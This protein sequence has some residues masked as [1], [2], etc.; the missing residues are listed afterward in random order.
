MRKKPKRFD[1]G[2]KWV[3]YDP[4]RGLWIPSRKRVFLYWFKFL[5]EAEKSNDYQVDW[6][7]Y[8]G[9]GGA[10][11]VLNT[12]F[13]DWWEERWITLFGYEGTRDGA[14]IDGQKPRYYLSTNRSKADG[15]RYAL[16]VYQNRH[17]GGTLE[18]AEWIKSYEE[19]KSQLRSGVFWLEETFELQSRIGRYRRNAY[20]ILENVAVGVFP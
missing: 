18:I 20:K 13:D 10:K 7:K 4:E 6:T 11:V 9:W 8:K 5:Q 2:S 12:K 14:F 19:K 15:I 16:M 3:R 17:R 1:P